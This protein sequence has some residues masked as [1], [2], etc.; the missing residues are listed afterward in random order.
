MRGA[1]GCRPVGR[2]GV[3][4]ER[5]EERGGDDSEDRECE[6]G[7][8]SDHPLQDADTA[9]D[10]GDVGFGSERDAAVVDGSHDGLG[11]GAVDA[12]AFEG[13]GFVEGVELCGHDMAPLCANRRRRMSSA[14]AGLTGF[15]LS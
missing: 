8:E 11:V 5:L 10:A 12:G 1:G 2:D 4:G 3:A 14:V 9:V 15:G 13:D 7:L 6:R